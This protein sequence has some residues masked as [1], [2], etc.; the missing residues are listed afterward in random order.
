MLIHYRYAS[1]INI[2]WK[3]INYWPNLLIEVLSPDSNNEP[4]HSLTP[5]ISLAVDLLSEITINSFAIFDFLIESV[6]GDIDVVI[7]WILEFIKDFIVITNFGSLVTMAWTCFR[8]ADGARL[9]QQY[10]A[11]G[12]A[13]AGGLILLFSGFGL[14]EGFHSQAREQGLDNIWSTYFYLVVLIALVSSI[15][16][17]I[18]NTGPTI[19][20]KLVRWGGSFAYLVMTKLGVDIVALTGDLNPT[21]GLITSTFIILTFV[22]FYWRFLTH[23][24]AVFS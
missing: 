23:L 21:T 22:F 10:Y 24:V 8:W 20:N 15:F 13:V 19:E 17:S 4:S 12:A 2:Q 6:G 3:L 9:I 1:F 11:M 7:G 16:G 18:P 14:V 5:L